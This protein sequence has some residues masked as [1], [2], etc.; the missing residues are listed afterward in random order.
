[1]IQTG[2]TERNRRSIYAPVG[3]GYKCEEIKAHVYNIGATRTINL[4][5]KTTQEISK[6][7]ACTIKNGAKFCNAFDQEDLGFETLAHP[8]E[9]EDL[10]NLVMVKR[11]EFAFK[12]YQNQIQC[13]LIASGKAFSVVL[14]QCLPASVD[15]VQVHEDWEQTS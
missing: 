13:Q 15:Q 9:Q 14:G 11:W 3:S 7:L 5:A 4:C 1:V 10:E 8:P 6:Y 2:S 12:T